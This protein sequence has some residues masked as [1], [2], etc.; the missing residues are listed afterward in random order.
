MDEI[1]IEIKPSFALLEIF[2]GK[3]QNF[4]QED[5]SNAVN[6]LNVEQL[7]ILITLY[8]KITFALF[9]DEN[10]LQIENEQ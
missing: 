10:N 2:L 5:W 9:A 1:K 3:T 4:T 7:Q 8:Q 6:N